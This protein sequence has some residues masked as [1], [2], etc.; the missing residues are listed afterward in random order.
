[1]DSHS[2]NIYNIKPV[3]SFPVLSLGDILSNHASIAQN[4]VGRIK[5]LAY[6][7]DYLKFGYYPYFIDNTGFYENTS[8]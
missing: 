7:S 4:V 5:P 1:M 2:E 6:F 8:I 3:N